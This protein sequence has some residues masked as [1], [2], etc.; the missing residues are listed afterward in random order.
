MYQSAKAR[1]QESEL[2]AAN[3]S[4]IGNEVQ[5]LLRN[6]MLTQG[7]SPIEI[8]TLNP[9]LQRETALELLKKYTYAPKA[10]YSYLFNINDGISNF[11]RYNEDFSKMVRGLTNMSPEEF[12]EEWKYFTN[13]EMKK[14]SFKKRTRFSKISERENYNKF[15]KT[16]ESERNKL[17]DEALKDRSTV[18][19]KEKILSA[20][21]K[22]MFI[23]Q[24]KPIEIRD[25]Y[26]KEERER[27]VI[28][29][30]EEDIAKDISKTSLE[31]KNTNDQIMKHENKLEELQN[32]EQEERSSWNVFENTTYINLIDAINN[33][34]PILSEE[35]KLLKEKKILQEENNIYI[36]KHKKKTLKIKNP[37]VSVIY[38]KNKKRII[39]I[40]NRLRTIRRK[41]K[42]ILNILGEEITGSGIKVRKITKSKKSK[43]INIPRFDWR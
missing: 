23:E 26:A 33:N 38:E 17:V 25:I 43:I 18:T 40:D 29:Q 5:Q 19:G 35:S 2:A 31:L 6:Q 11:I 27:N 7:I 9:N 3:D 22:S 4:F 21:N 24:K 41:K 37:T 34:L 8:E 36:K 28:Q 15:L 16:Q 20:I 12:K 30:E 32:I 10:V 13:V 39:Q 42:P 1:L 14:E